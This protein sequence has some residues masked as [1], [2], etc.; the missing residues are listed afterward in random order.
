MGSHTSIVECPNINETSHLFAHLQSLVDIDVHCPSICETTFTNVVVPRQLKL[1]NTHQWVYI[2]GGS[3][4]RLLLGH[5]DPT[6]HDIDLF[7][8]GPT[9]DIRERRIRKFI[10]SVQ[11][12]VT[13]RSESYVEVIQEDGTQLHIIMTSHQTIEE[14]VK[15][16]DFSV[17]R[18]WLNKKHEIQAFPSTVFS[19]QNKLN[20]AYGPQKIVSCSRV[21]HIQD[22]FKLRTKIGPYIQV[23]SM[24]HNPSTKIIPKDQPFTPLKQGHVLFN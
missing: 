7:V 13:R 8:V 19:I 18:L 21:S 15:Q 17:C 4:V 9:E 23:V 6:T 20:Y 2:A 1:L 3:L 11:G 10:K 12:K 5:Y 22:L 16:F 24:S 14:V